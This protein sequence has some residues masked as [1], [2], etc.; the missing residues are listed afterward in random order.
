[1]NLEQF[2]KWI[3]FFKGAKV[4]I[5]QGSVVWTIR[6]GWFATDRQQAYV[7]LFRWASVGNSK[8]KIY[9]TYTAKAE[10]LRLS[11]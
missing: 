11:T 8:V 9:K 1:M 4:V 6:S 5:G 2:T 3:S 10:A 7:H